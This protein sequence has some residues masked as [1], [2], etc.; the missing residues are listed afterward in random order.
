MVGSFYIVIHHICMYTPVHMNVLHMYY[1]C[2]W[3]IFIYTYIHVHVY[4]VH[5]IVYYRLVHMHM[6]IT[7]REKYNFFDVMLQQP[8]LR[9]QYAHHIAHHS[10]LESRESGN[11]RSV[12]MVCRLE[13]SLLYT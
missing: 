5:V 8:L 6:H 1:T 7:Q 12:C 10:L 11:H 3:Y 9:Y 2:M 13:F 4:V